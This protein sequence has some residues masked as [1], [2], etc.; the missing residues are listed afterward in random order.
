M[1]TMTYTEKSIVEAY[2]ILFNNLSDMCR[3][4]L[5]KKLSDVAQKKQRA[6]NGFDLSFGGWEGADQSI[7]EIKAEIKANRKFKEKD[8]IFA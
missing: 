8:P 1:A 5:T 3:V 4:A 6:A 2:S 7:D